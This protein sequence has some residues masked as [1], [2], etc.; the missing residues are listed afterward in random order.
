MSSVSHESSGLQSSMIFLTTRSTNIKKVYDNNYSSVIYYFNGSISA[1]E[2]FIFLVSLND[3]IIPA[4]WYVISEHNDNNT[5]N[6]QINS[7]Q[8]SYVISDGNYSISDLV[9]LFNSSEIYVDNG[10]ST[11]FDPPT[12]KLIFQNENNLEFTFLYISTCFELLGFTLD[13]D[14]DSEGFILIGDDQCD[15]SG[16]REIYVKSSLNTLNLD[17]RIGSL[18]SNILAKIPVTVDSNNFI[19]YNNVTGYRS[20]LKDKMINKIE[21]SLED[22]KGNLIDITHHYSCTIEIQTIPDKYLVYQNSMSK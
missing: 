21:I 6:Y 20:I 13:I 16:T 12:N 22:D 14:H 9:D 19:Y 10:I 18:S 1:P 11:Y 4:T 8:Y 7:H 3:M 5:L 2:G 17:S 15:V